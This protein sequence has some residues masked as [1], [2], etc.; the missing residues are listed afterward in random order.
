MKSMPTTA[1]LPAAG[2]YRDK[3]RRSSSRIA[4]SSST[5]RTRRAGAVEVA[6][7]SVIGSLSPRCDT[8]PQS[9]QLAYPKLRRFGH[10]HRGEIGI[11]LQAVTPTL[12]AGLGL[13]QDWGAM[14]SDVI[15]G[16]PASAAGFRPG[17]IVLSIDNEPV[18]GLPRLAF[19]FFTRSAGDVVRLKVRRGVDLYT[20]DVTA[21]ERPHDF[22][23]LTDLVDPDKSL[24]ARLGVLGVD[25]TEATAAMA[26]NLRAPIGV[27]VVGHT[28]SDGD[29]ADSGLQTGDA[30]H[31]VNGA[32]IASVAEL[33]SVLA[34]IGPRHAIVLQIERNGQ[35]VFLAF[36][37]DRRGSF[38]P[39]NSSKTPAR[40]RA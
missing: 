33:R 38:V 15:P 21:V 24:I 25:I 6:E 23:R 2:W 29:A 13:S 14:I 35:F 37:G 10:L 40:R 19:Q 17:D 4:V 12:A 31:S 28:K 1:G 11:L 34:G 32:P 18:D 26:S 20:A 3:C 30:V 22:D 8:L 9:Q 39:L 36:E 16:S 7:A 27:L 5:S